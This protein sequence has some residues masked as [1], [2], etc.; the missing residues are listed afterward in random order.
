MP[1]IFGV[2]GGIGVK[3]IIISKENSIFNEMVL[4]FL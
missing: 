1:P 2:L 3:Y 4:D